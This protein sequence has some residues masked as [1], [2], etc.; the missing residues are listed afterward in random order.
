MGNDYAMKVIVEQFKKGNQ[1]LDR[2]ARYLLGIYQEPEKVTRRIQTLQWI[3]LF[4][5]M[6]ESEGARHGETRS[7]SIFRSIL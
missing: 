4:P 7:G 5:L 2:I 3:R 1:N 6:T